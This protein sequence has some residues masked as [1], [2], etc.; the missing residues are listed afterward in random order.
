MPPDQAALLAS[1]A[2]LGAPPRVAIATAG[3]NG[4]GS[5]VCAQLKRL[6]LRALVYVACCLD[7]AARDVA[8]LLGGGK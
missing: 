1:L 3:R 4:V 8:L 6:P 5:A 7:T 2:A